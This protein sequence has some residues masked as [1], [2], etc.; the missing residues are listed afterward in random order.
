[1]KGLL[2]TKQQYDILESKNIDFDIFDPIQLTKQ[3]KIEIEF[4]SDTQFYKACELLN[5]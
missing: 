2:I 3:D 1:M 4:Y 5:I